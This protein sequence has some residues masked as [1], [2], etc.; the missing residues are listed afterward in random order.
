MALPRLL[1]PTSPPPE[2]DLCRIP[3]K[4]PSFRSPSSSWDFSLAVLALGP[5]QSVLGPL[6]SQSRL[7]HTLPSPG[8]LALCRPKIHL[9]GL[10]S[11]LSLEFF[12]LS[13]R[14]SN[15]E[16]EFRR[17]QYPQM[18]ENLLYVQQI[19]LAQIYRAPAAGGALGSGGNQGSISPHW[20]ME[21]RGT[22]ASVIHIKAEACCQIIKQFTPLSCQFLAC[23][24]LAI[25]PTYGGCAENRK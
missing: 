10:S 1:L 7:F 17:N 22:Q 20:A 18:E 25:V 11:F 5:W 8:H 21:G 6:T 19:N 23:G 13:W 15:R 16:M 4:C 3:A 2:W 9:T 24:M 14:M 12:S